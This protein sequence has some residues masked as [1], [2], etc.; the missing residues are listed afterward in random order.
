MLTMQRSKN[1]VELRKLRDLTGLKVTPTKVPGEL[2]LVHASESYVDP[3]DALALS[4]QANC[5]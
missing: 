1:E 3:T 4:S 5:E 2:L